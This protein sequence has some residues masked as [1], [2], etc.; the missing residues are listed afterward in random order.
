MTDITF[1]MNDYLRGRNTVIDAASFPFWE[2]KASQVVRNITCGNI[3][4]SEPIPEV[5]QMCVCEVAETLYL[6]VKSESSGRVIASEKVGG[7]SVTYQAQSEAEKQAV[8]LNIIRYWL[9]ETGL[10]YMGVKKC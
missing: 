9:S 1:Y 10:M 5:V 7:H 8:I 6:I 4:E 2:M 3:D